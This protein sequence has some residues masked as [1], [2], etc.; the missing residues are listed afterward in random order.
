MKREEKREKRKVKSDS[1]K[2][3]TLNFSLSLF[4]LL[5]LLSSCTKTLSTAKSISLPAYKQSFAANPNQI[6]YA[7]R[8]ALKAY[9]YPIAEEDLQNGIVKSRIVPV[10][11]TSHYVDVFKHRDFGVS[12]AYHQLEVRLVPQNGRTEVQVA[13]KVQGVVKNIKSTGQEETLILTKVGDYL[14]SANTS[15]TNLGVQ[16]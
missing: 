1:L 2:L 12:G 14:R 11:A 16:E 6:Y 13:S 3:K 4:S 15:V 8:W 7:L 5:F 10:K 9:D